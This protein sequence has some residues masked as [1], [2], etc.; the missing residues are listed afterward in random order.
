MPFSLATALVILALAPSWL[1]FP[2]VWAASREHGFA[3][4]G[5]CLWLVWQRRDAMRARSAPVPVAMAAVAVASIVW[6][7]AIEAGIEVGHLL[8][9][10][11]ILL[12]WLTATAGA[13]AAWA[14]A[15]IVLTFMLAIPVWES[16]VPLLQSMTV[17][18]NQA[19]LGVLGIDAQIKETYIILKSGVLEVADSCSGLNFL[20]VGTTVATAYAWIFASS[21]RNRFRILITGIVLA[22]LAN[23][24]RVLGLVLVADATNMKSPLMTDHE[25]FGWSIFV[26]ALAVFFVVARRLEDSAE[27]APDVHPA[28]LSDSEGTSHPRYAAAT[29]LALLGPVSLAI[30][31]AIPAVRPTTLPN[32]GLVLGPQWREVRDTTARRAPAQFRGA[33]LSSRAFSNGVTT[34]RLDRYQYASEKPD[35]ELISSENHVAPDSAILGTRQVGPL[36]QSFRLVRETAIRDA[37][38]VVLIWSWYRIGDHETSSS[39]R[40]KLFRFLAALERR[41]DA[42]AVLL[43]A[44]CNG[45]NCDATYASMYLLVTGRELPRPS[46][47]PSKTQ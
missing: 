8:L 20:L 34:V 5:L 18:A 42:E 17:A 1:R 43:S 45:T 35:A 46:D 36:D 15:P 39:I 47:Q 25:V 9:T 41:T 29:A 2:S 32:A 28:R 22:L 37:G 10:P 31:A 21:Q 33:T 44:P 14:A 26:V 27:T 11:L 16:L 38:N 7:V 3:V 30:L 13:A 24:V 4:A 23:W 6:W 12:L 40:G 19:V